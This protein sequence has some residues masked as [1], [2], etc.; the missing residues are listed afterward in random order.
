MELTQNQFINNLKYMLNS[1]TLFF[2]DDEL[3]IINTF[4]KLVNYDNKSY[5]LLFKIV[6]DNK[7]DILF[8]K[9]GEDDIGNSNNMYDNDAI[10]F[11]LKSFFR[12]YV[13]QSEIENFISNK[14]L[15]IIEND[16]DN[17]IQTS[18]IAILINSINK[19]E[20][21]NHFINYHAND[22]SISLE[23]AMELISEFNEDIS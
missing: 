13:K 17:N 15:E 21:H 11:T 23:E 18:N 7:R 4:K 9:E 1:T 19:D 8:K 5:S 3:N 20:Y 12:K 22:N 10:L 6:I 2:E 16:F 14:F